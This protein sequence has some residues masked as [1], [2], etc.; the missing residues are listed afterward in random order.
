MHEVQKK[1]ATELEIIAATESKIK[2]YHTFAN[3]NINIIND[4]LEA[5]DIHLSLALLENREGDEQIVIFGKEDTL[6]YPMIFGTLKEQENVKKMVA[7]IIGKEQERLNLSAKLRVWKD[8]A[9]DN[10]ILL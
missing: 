7:E 3:I 10:G 4:Q 6:H 1:I 2:R 8:L 5:N 9:D